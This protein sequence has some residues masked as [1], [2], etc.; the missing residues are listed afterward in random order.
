MDERIKR[1]HESILTFDALTGL[2]HVEPPGCPGFCVGEG[3]EIAIRVGHTRVRRDREY[4]ADT[5][6]RMDAIKKGME[7]SGL[8]TRECLR[9][10]LEEMAVLETKWGDALREQSSRTSNGKEQNWFEVA[11]PSRL[12]KARNAVRLVYDFGRKSCGIAFPCASEN[13]WWMFLCCLARL[14]IRLPLDIRRLLYE[15]VDTTCLG[16]ALGIWRSWIPQLESKPICPVDNCVVWSVTK[17][18]DPLRFQ[19]KL[20]LQEWIQHHFTKVHGTDFINFV[21][22]QG[23]CDCTKWLHHK[24]SEPTEDYYWTDECYQTTYCTNCGVVVIPRTL[25]RV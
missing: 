1:L 16:G 10:L 5:I 8:V 7:E 9:A 25:E 13:V 17:H 22:N 24:H 3:E 18:D 12:L 23:K 21:R 6:E 15:Y 2:C 19:S 11:D 4:L 14:R 20:F